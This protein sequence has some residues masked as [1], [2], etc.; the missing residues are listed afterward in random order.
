MPGVEGELG[1]IKYNPKPVD[2]IS[3]ETREE[4]E[5]TK[6]KLDKFK[7][8]IMKKHPYIMALGILPPF[9]I[10]KFEEEAALT[11]EEIKEKPIHVLVIIPEDKF[12]DIKKIRKEMVDSV[13]G[14]KPTLWI[15][16]MTPVDVWNYGLDAKYDMFEGIAMCFPLHDNGLLGSLR[17][18]QIHKNLVLRKFENYVTSYVIAGSLVAG[19]ATKTSDVD[20]YVIINDTDVKRMPRLELKEKLRGIIYTYIAEAEELAGVKNKLNIQVYILTEFWEG[21]KD[22]HPV[23][24]TFIRDGVPMYDK[25]TFMPWKLLLK[26]GKIK[27][28]PE[29][30]DVFMRSG[31]K[32][33]DTVK[34]ML[35]DNLTLDIYWGVLTPSQGLLMLYGVAPPKPRDTV[36]E[37]KRIFVDKE[38]LLEKKYIDIFDKIVS[39]YKDV[40]HG[41]IKEMTGVQID[42]FL[43]DAQSYM[44]RLGELR[45]QIEKRVQENTINQVYD[46]L[47]K[48]LKAL[49]G[50]KSA[51]ALVEDFESSFIKKG[52]FPEVYLKILKDVVKAK[53]DFK[54]GKLTGNDVENVRKNAS[55][56]VNNLI[57]YNQR[58]ELIA[59]DKGRF[60]LL[61]RD[62]KM[63]ELILAGG[64]AFLI[65]EGKLEKVENKLVN[66]GKDD[67][68]RALT[69]QKNN[70]EIKTNSKVFEVLRKELGDFEVV[71]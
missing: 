15:H 38:K 54:K 49:F 60:R 62:G 33:K 13:K 43:E 16:V 66:C 23:F 58:C 6:T 40:E 68:E 32:M 63:C 3:D 11:P 4:M 37:M 52:K 9:A 71:F 25:G 5:K 46:D 8:D 19:N 59:L 65:R 17:V 1:S 29:A 44:K 36:T 12:K 34:K 42:K 39:T 28:S 67:L 48:M 30:I 51:S 7:K 27:P 35:M 20:V 56:I 41:K 50:N 57:E 21:V 2:N 18:A 53:E 61:L 22:A 55:V 26:M 64:Q 24:F 45:K 10:P 31:D 69:E 70:L 14:F 47:I